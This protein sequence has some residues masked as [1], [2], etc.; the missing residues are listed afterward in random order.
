MGRLHC[1]FAGPVGAPVR[2]QVHRPNNVTIIVN[3]PFP[4]EKGEWGASTVVLLALLVRRYV[5]KWGAVQGYHG[6]NSC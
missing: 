4:I 6:S 3:V 1:R 5:A 2:S